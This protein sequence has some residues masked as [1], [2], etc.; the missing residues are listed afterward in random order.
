MA[1]TV[2][3]RSGKEEYKWLTEVLKCDA[4]SF[5][6]SNTNSEKFRAEVNKCKSAILYHSK[7]RGRV[8]ITDVTDSLYDDELK[9]L[10]S[11]LGKDNVIVVVDDLDDS[12]P[13]AKA[14]I[15]NNQQSINR[16]AKDL[17]L[18]T[19]EDKKDKKIQETMKPIIE[20]L[21]GSINKLDC[22]LIVLYTITAST[23]VNAF[24]RRSFTNYQLAL[25]WIVISCRKKYVG[26]S[27]P[28][29]PKCPGES[30]LLT[31]AA[32]GTGG[33][34]LFSYCRRF[35]SFITERFPNLYR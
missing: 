29:L 23:V 35:P 18:F 13:E 14:R 25:F 7:N 22:R 33:Y 21:S 1:V 10:S 34:L 9:Y 8:N 15:L 11:K 20:I 16:F 27:R 26:S 3:S 28:L 6:I 17:F 30:T 12:G 2:F 32:F 4:G 19:K 24:S 5:Y 31:L